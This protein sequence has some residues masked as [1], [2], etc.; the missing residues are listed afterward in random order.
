VVAHF[1]LGVAVLEGFVEDLSG[2]A[3]G[4]GEGFPGMKQ[5]SSVV[6]ALQLTQYPHVSSLEMRSCRDLFWVYGGQ[7]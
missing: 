3:A 4:L 6:V 1:E 7:G 2:G 5:G